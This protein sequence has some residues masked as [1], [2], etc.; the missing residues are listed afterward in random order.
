MPR[1]PVSV[2]SA[3]GARHVE[4]P[5]D[6]SR[7]DLAVDLA[8]PRRVF[9]GALSLSSRRAERLAVGRGRCEKIKIL[10]PLRYVIPE[11]AFSR[12]PHARGERGMDLIRHSP[13]VIRN[14]PRCLTSRSL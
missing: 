2:L 7:A 1:G 10:W 14:F 6:R 5:A 9:R 3:P 8:I 12:G 11:S 13:F 4:D